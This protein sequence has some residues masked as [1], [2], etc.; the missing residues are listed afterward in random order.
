MDSKSIEDTI[1]HYKELAKELREIETEIKSLI[2]QEVRALLQEWGLGYCISKDEEG[3]SEGVLLF[4][5]P[6]WV[7]PNVIPLP[8]E[9]THDDQSVEMSLGVLSLASGYIWEMLGLVDHKCRWMGEGIINYI[10][11]TSPP[12]GLVWLKHSW[13][14]EKCHLK[15][16]DPQEEELQE[17]YTYLGPMSWRLAEIVLLRQE[18]NPGESFNMQMYFPSWQLYRD[19]FGRFVLSDTGPV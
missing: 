7:Y 2:S 6:G 11:L 14:R 4:H 16:V 10:P 9:Y 5:A 8:K 3:R 15:L 13:P 19:P 17:G 1:N 12:G 18:A